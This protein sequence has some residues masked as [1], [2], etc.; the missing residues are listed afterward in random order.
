[1]RRGGHYPGVPARGMRRFNRRYGTAMRSLSGCLPVIFV[2]GFLLS[3][4]YWREMFSILILI[5][6]IVVGVM[7]FQKY[8]SGSK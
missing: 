7:L 8:C 5:V 3:L 1:M 6:G 4:H 2:V